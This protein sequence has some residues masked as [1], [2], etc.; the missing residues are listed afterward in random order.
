MVPSFRILFYR[1]T[2]LPN[3]W[4]RAFTLSE[5]LIAVA[6][7]G[8]IATFT[9]PKV[10]VSVRNTQDKA[11]AKETVATIHSVLFEGWQN[12]SINAN[13]LDSDVLTVLQQKLN[14]TSYCTSTCSTMASPAY[15]YGD[16]FDRNVFT[17]GSGATLTL[18]G[19]D[20][21]AR[22]WL[23]VFID[24]NGPIKGP[25]SMTTADGDIIS[26][27][28]NKSNAPITAAG[29]FV[30]LQPGNFGA[31]LEMGRDIVYKTLLGH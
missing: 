25:N 30:N 13:T 15:P 23:L 22:N 9:I 31:D 18:W 7:L 11:I 3:F 6:I 21:T 24:I 10:L 1:L 8:L 5:L 17:F 12:G 20:G 4:R 14:A 26:L 28:Y 2:F 29:N 19:V 27:Y 16:T